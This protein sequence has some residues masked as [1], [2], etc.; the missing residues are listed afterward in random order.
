MGSLRG[1][2][3][4][5][6]AEQVE[7][8]RGYLTA[9]SGIDVVAFLRDTPPA[10]LEAVI[11]EVYTPDVELE[12]VDTSLDSGPFHGRDGLLAGFKE[13]LDSFED[14]FLVPIEY[15]DAGDEVVVPNEQRGRG[16]GS[17]ADVEM[18]TTW[19]CTVRDGKIS[20]LREFSTKEKALETV[21]LGGVSG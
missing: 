11:A 12:W 3:P 17:G 16:K 20:R 19:V 5:M 10:D 9:F 21:G 1:I 15:I 8:V 7:A 4:P 18:T 6:G 13:W 14:F 2:L